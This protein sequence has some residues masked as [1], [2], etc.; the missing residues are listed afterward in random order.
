MAD[1]VV[2][3]SAF[4]P[5]VPA[6]PA[7]RTL[8]VLA[9]PGTALADEPAVFIPVGTPGIDHAAHVFRSDTVVALRAR[10]LID[11][12]LPDAATV[13][14]AIAAALPEEAPAC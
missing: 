7:E 1:A 6:F 5:E 4:R 2:W 14:K 12:G 10:G 13:L 11:R 3:V 8:I 9:P